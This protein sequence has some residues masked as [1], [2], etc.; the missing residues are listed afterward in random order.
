VAPAEERP[1]I[2][3]IVRGRLVARDQELAEAIA[4]WRKAMAG[5][6]GVLLISGAPG[7]G[8]TRLANEMVA[9]ARLFGAQV[10]QGGCYEYEATTP[11]LPLTEA[12]RDWAH[13]QATETLREQLGTTAAEL[14]RLVP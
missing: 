7:V 8:K 4:I 1:L 14:A 13:A 9:H 11:Y 12:L 6:S 2:E 10:L 5:E 3:R